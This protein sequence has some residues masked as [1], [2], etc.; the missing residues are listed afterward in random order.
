MKQ[1][2]VSDG[3]CVSQP[4]ADSRC[5]PWTPA[6]R[7]STVPQLTPAHPRASSPLVERDK[8]TPALGS[9]HR[10]PSLG[11]SVYVGPCPD[12]S[13]LI[14]RGTVATL[15]GHVT[16]RSGPCSVFTYPLWAGLLVR[17]EPNWKP[18]KQ[19]RSPSA[20][21]VGVLLR[22]A[23]LSLRCIVSSS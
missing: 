12:S 8:H 22:R 18:V 3:S 10:S 19:V 2:P 16:N 1:I 4:T 11:Q 7:V 6:A 13:L 23:R 21:N 15:P 9:C 20:R 17:K 14:F 5:G